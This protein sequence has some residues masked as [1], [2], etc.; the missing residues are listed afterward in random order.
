MQS[1]AAT[2]IAL[3][4]SMLV[5]TCTLNMGV[6]ERTRQ[7]ALLRAITLTRLQLGMLVF[8]ESL[9]LG[10]GGLLIGSLVG[11]GML[12][13][14]R[15]L[16]PTLYYNGIHLGVNTFSMAVIACLGAA[17]LASLSP[18][19]MA[20][21]VRPIDALTSLAKPLRIYQVR[22]GVLLL[23]IGLIGFNWVWHALPLSQHWVVIGL[24][25]GMILS[26]IGFV[27]LTPSLVVWVDYWLT[28]VLCRVF[29]VDR[30]LIRSQLTPHVW[31][32]SG[33]AI[34][35]ALGT[36]L[37]I[38]IQ[39]WGYTM[40]QAFVPGDWA[41]DAVIQLAENS[42][43]LPEDVREMAEVSERQF[44]K[45]VVEQP[46]LLEDLTDSAQAAT[47]TRQDNIILV[48]VEP[49]P[50][51]AAE[52][53]LFRMEWKQGDPVKAIKALRDNRGCVVPNHF[54]ID[55]GMK[56]GDEFQV[57]SPEDA[58]KVL[59]YTI[60]G[61]VALPGWH[62]QTKLTGMRP[63]THRAAALVFTDYQT[64][65]ND[66]QFSGPTHV[67]FDFSDSQTTADDR[68]RSKLATLEG[69]VVSSTEPEGLAAEYAEG[70]AMISRL[71]TVSLIRNHINGVARRWIWI[72]SQLPLVTL[73]IAGVGVLNVLLA[74]VRSRKREYGI[75]ISIGFTREELSRAVF[76]EGILVA[77][78]A[79]FLSIGFGIVA[80]W[81][82]CEL[83]Q[84]LSF[85]G[86]LHPD[87][88]VPPATLLVAVL[89]IA[90]FA[91]LLSFWPARMIG[92]SRPLELLQS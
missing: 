55:T 78:V 10:I 15:Q 60:A 1:Y 92:K 2:G 80:G 65:V 87:L 73:L 58:S 46:R 56:V 62:W 17:V 69:R 16:V 47:V 81:S 34:T 45:V 90:G 76:L 64:M 4:V 31:R 38:G 61:S 49:D 59:T 3:L 7:Y 19:Y 39:V 14:V 11:I 72:I 30:D 6:T 84:Y 82:G 51:F 52:D 33:A 36:G 91:V 75:L 63:R 37:F 48:G 43:V 85:F 70:P 35:M 27:L 29:R 12:L 21:R 22:A 79:S 5:I 42:S 20:T 67:W 8:F 50:S 24:A 66:F 68:V 83:A 26:T 57:V 40:L 44:S 9:F 88:V 18:I 71:V 25:A 41:P 89:M 53:P 23:A 86:G 32:T 54:L 13:V 74:S 77:V 28:P